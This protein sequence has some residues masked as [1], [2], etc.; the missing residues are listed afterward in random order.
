M[1]HQ[2]VSRV[3]IVGSLLHRS[4][5]ALS[6][7]LDAMRLLRFGR[8]SHSL[9]RGLVRFWEPRR[10]SLRL[11]QEAIALRRRSTYFPNYVE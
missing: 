11:L 9:S 1:H 3:L 7:T 8:L 10:P 6:F 4:C 5:D 2:R